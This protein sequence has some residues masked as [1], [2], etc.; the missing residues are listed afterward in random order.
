MIGAVTPRCRKS[1]SSTCCYVVPPT[2]LR[3]GFQCPII[4]HVKMILDLCI[5]RFGV[6]ITVYFRNMFFAQQIL[7]TSFSKK[8]KTKLSIDPA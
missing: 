1:L 5:I 8:K 3:L 2:S 7:K 6:K 4:F